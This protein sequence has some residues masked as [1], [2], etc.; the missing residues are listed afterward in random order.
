MQ[1]QI[2]DSPAL[3]GLTSAEADARAAQ[4]AYQPTKRPRRKI[5]RRDH[6]LQHPDVFQP[7]FCR[8]CGASVPRR[9]LP[10]PDVSAG[11]RRK[12][13]HRH[14]PGAARQADSGQNESSAC[15]ACRRAARWAGMS[16]CRRRAGTG[17]RSN[18]CR[19]DQIPADATVLAGCVQVN[20]ALLTGESDEIEKAPAAACFPAASSSRA[21][22][23]P[24]STASETS[25]ISQSSRARQKLF[26]RA[27]SRK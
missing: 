6:S 18:S 15:A 5:R 26:P 2:P 14:L 10:Q 4:G 19:G 13:S 22:A 9:L 1:Q 8:H 27:S 25:R 3:R 11:R 23:M 12:H 16:A 21:G 7:D 20:E 17:R 24:G